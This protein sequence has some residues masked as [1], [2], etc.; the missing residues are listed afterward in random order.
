MGK[1]Y[2]D[3][4]CTIAMAPFYSNTVLDI[5]LINLLLGQYQRMAQLFPIL[6]TLLVYGL[7]LLLY[8]Y[9]MAQSYS[10]GVL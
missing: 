2:S 8:N 5:F 4:V 1:H 10:N 3:T 9:Y 6:M 7:I